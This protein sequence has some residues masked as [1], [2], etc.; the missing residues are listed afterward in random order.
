MSLKRNSA[1]QFNAITFVPLINFI[2]CPKGH[3][4]PNYRGQ[5][6][7]CLVFKPKRRWGARA[8]LR[9]HLLSQARNG[10]NMV[11]KLPK[12]REGKPKQL[13]SVFKQVPVEINPI[14]LWN[15]LRPEHVLVL[16]LWPNNGG[17][18]KKKKEKSYFLKKIYLVLVVTQAVTK[19]QTELLFLTDIKKTTWRSAI[20]KWF[21]FPQR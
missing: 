10:P 19:K 5:A 6:R 1:R 2:L 9:F 8:C 15:E 16:F 13:F 3:F 21:I 12:R 18:N 11:H 20:D 7:Y 17:K 14:V 4:D